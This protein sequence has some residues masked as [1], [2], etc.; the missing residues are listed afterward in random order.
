MT[1]LTSTFP[2]AASARSAQVRGEAVTADDRTVGALGVV[3]S[4]V[5]VDSASSD[6]GSF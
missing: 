5:A 6:E 1:S 2:W 4:E 3:R